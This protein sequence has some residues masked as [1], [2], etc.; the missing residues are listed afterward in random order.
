MNLVIYRLKLISLMLIAFQL[1]HAQDANQSIN[2][3]TYIDKIKKSNL[4]SK[5]AQSNYELAKK[6]VQQSNA[7]FLPNIGLTYTGMMTNS[8]LMAFGTRLNQKSVTMQD[9][10]PNRLNDPDAIH[11]FNT[12]IEVQQPIINIDGYFGRLAA[13]SKEM[14]TK[15]QTERT[16][17]YVEL[18]AYKAYLMLQLTY[19]AEEVLAR[20]NRTGDENLKLVENYNKQ[21]MIQKSDLLNAMVRV[22]EIRDQHQSAKT[23][24]KN[25]SDY[26]S[27][28]MNESSSNVFRPVETL[29]TQIVI[30]QFNPELN[31]NRKDIKAM[32]EATEAYRN[33]HQMSNYSMVP[34]LNAFGAYEMNDKSM[35]GFGATNYMVGV[36]LAWN[37][38]DG[39]KSISKSQ[40]SKLEFI[41]A[42]DEL[43]HYKSQNRLELNK[44][45]RQIQDIARKVQL[46]KLAHNQSKEAYTIRKNRFDQG[47]EKTSD[48]LQSETMMYQKE[49]EYLQSVFEYNLT[50]K[51]LHFLTQYE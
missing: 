37:I 50:K 51:Y 48:L 23:N 21:G 2:Y 41:K 8:P 40:K 13:K 17:E 16:Q 11:N 36:Q 34:R 47:L 10:D 38:F 19:K 5:L 42:K 39:N 27:F 32:L 43:E 20:A 31:E 28:L 35:V 14:A 30:L 7:L 4:Q 15:L 25:A 45:V 1:I 26:L 46:M 9:F 44:A 22:Q 18:E 24:I 12:K 33:M 3:A 49:L 6:D 29:D